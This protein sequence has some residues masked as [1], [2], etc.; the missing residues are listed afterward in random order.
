MVKERYENGRL[1]SFDWRDKMQQEPRINLT[2]ICI[3]LA[4]IILVFTY[5]FIKG[6]S[7]YSA[8]VLIVLVGWL[9]I[10]LTLTI[11]GICMLWTSYYE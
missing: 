3:I 11:I 10:M 2:R 6:L 4:T 7:I 9:G 8:F 5:A 1:K